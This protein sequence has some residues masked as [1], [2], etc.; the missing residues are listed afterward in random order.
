MP[1]RV[2]LE[3][4]ILSP[5]RITSKWWLT[6]CHTE[7]GMCEEREERGEERTFAMVVAAS[8]NNG[9]YTMV[10]EREREQKETWGL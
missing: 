10:W 7:V 9:G 2:G 6:G 3:R 1:N 4:K 5:N 8:F